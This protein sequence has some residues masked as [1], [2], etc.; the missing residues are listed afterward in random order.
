[1]LE[2]PAPNLDSMLCWPS[3]FGI[4]SCLASQL[5]ISGLAVVVFFFFLVLDVCDCSLF[6]AWI[7]NFPSALH[8]SDCK[9]LEG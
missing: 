9:V 4:T 7:D 2:F 8:G 3:V 5:A 6:G 1:M